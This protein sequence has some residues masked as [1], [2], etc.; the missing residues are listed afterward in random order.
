M[1]AVDAQTF[2]FIVTGAGAAGRSFVYQLLH[3]PLRESKVLLIDQERKTTD[4]R[5][6]CFWES[7]PGPFEE[8][9]HYRWPELWFHTYDYTRQLDIAPFKYKMVKAADYYQFT[10]EC[11]SKHKNVTVLLADVEQVENL[12][13]GGGVMVQTSAGA[14]QGNWCINSIWRGSID[15]QR[16][17]Y[18]DQH[19]KGWFVRTQ[20]PV[21]SDADATLM[22]FRVPQEGDFR[23]MYVFPDSPHTALFELA[24]FSNEHLTS[25]GYDEII[26]RY[27]AAYW[28][29]LL[30]YE[31]VRDEAGVIPMT[32]FVFPT[33]DQRIVNVGTAGGDTR[34]STGYTFIYI[35]RRIERLIKAL[36]SGDQRLGD[37]N[38]FGQRHRYYDSLMLKVLA[39]DRYPGD[40]LFGRLFRNNPPARLL[41][42]L[43]GESSVPEELAVMST[44][45]I[46]TFLRALVGA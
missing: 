7:T 10:D 38:W 20:E 13:N 26:K 43:N 16:V 17:Q 28:P 4:D 15:K 37:L 39:E 27:I 24:I 35:H 22:D 41:R 23:F 36:Q 21:F 46:P 18:L 33:R 30:G 6:W 19:F 11:F 9:V 34:A 8:I 32:D 1:S 12:P 42:F 40:Q 3:S 5:T 14:Y 29:Q 25:A 44:A 31:V 45:P 2:D